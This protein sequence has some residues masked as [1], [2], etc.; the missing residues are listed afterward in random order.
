MSEGQHI[1]E[2]PDLARQSNSGAEI[3]DLL[4]ALW[5]KNFPILVE[6]LK[7]IRVATDQLIRGYIDESARR[8]GEAAAHKLSGILGTFGL[9]RGSVLSSKIE[10][11]LAGDVLACAQRAAELT[12]WFQELEA[13]I[14]SHR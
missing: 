1:T 13:V 3:D 7:A 12:C 2:Q 4:Q 6:R 14:A 10:A 8:D 5:V 11:L 9:P